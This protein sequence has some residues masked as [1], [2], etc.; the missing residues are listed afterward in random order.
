MT[1]KLRGF[2]SLTAYQM[3]KLS[4]FDDGIRI[5]T[6]TI[7]DNSSFLFART[8]REWSEMKRLLDSAKYLKEADPNVDVLESVASLAHSYNYS[9][10]LTS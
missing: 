7:I 4:I 1:R 10:E 6:I 8:S 5:A 2:D 3:R 9:T